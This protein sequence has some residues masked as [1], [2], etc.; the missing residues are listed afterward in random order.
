MTEKWKDI[1]AWEGFYQV[2]DQGRVRSVDRT[3]VVRRSN[4]MQVPL[5]LCGRMLRGQ[6]NKG[7]ETVCLSRPGKQVRARVHGLVLLAFVGA[8]PPN[9]EACH[10]NGKRADN[11]LGNLRYDTR[12]ANCMDRHRHGTHGLVYGEASGLAKLT[13]KTVRWARANAE[14]FSYREMG[15]RLGVST[16]TIRNAVLGINW[17][18]V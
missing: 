12:S 13:E 4:G 6:L 1:P 11:R 8:K 18:H 5:R 3:I 9:Q 17:K 15:R 2:S 7:Y 14:Q 16:N 10:W